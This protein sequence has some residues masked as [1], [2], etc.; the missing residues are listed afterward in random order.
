MESNDK[1]T[2]MQALVSRNDEDVLVR[3]PGLFSKVGSKGEVFKVLSL[4]PS[5]LITGAH[6]D[7]KRLFVRKGDIQSYI[8]RFH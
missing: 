8:F 3:Y 7:G 1:K 5:P 6:P 4:G 2:G